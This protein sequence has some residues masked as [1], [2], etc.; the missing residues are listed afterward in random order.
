M[1]LPKPVTS[2]EKK[3]EEKTQSLT[4]PSA[5]ISSK[6]SEQTQ[7]PTKNAD[8]NNDSIVPHVKP[9]LNKRLKLKHVAF[10]DHIDETMPEFFMDT[11]SESEDDEQ[12]GEQNAPLVY[13]HNIFS[14]YQMSEVKSH[15][16]I[17]KVEST[18][19]PTVDLSSVV[20]EDDDSQDFTSLDAFYAAKPDDDLAEKEDDMYESSLIRL[21]MKPSL[22]LN[23]EYAQRADSD[24]SLS[25]TNVKFALRN[26][27]SNVVVAIKSEPVAVLPQLKSV[28]SL[29]TLKTATND[30]SAS[31][32]FATLLADQS[33]KIAVKSGADAI[34]VS[35]NQEQ[36]MS[37]VGVEK[38]QPQ[39]AFVNNKIR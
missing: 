38:K 1:A 7:N 15:E 35:A 39:V 18:N 22:G 10:E 28:E 26:L 36:Q 34:V 21:S 3:D 31:S 11:T 6:E 27:Q 17:N 4:A 2:L 9:M 30:C 5:T 23:D 19:T 33:N 32:V 14:V 8:T 37:D 16:L 12:N 24:L 25:A 20:R 29:S 13:G